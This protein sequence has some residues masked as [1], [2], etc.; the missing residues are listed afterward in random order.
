MAT[1]GAMALIAA[2]GIDL[3]FAN[4]SEAL[5]LAGAPDLESAIERLA[6]Q[7]K[8]L[9]F[10]R[11]PAGAVAYE[12][13]TLTEVPAISVPQVVDTTGAGDAFLAGYLAAYARGLTDGQAGL[14]AG[15]RW[16]AAMVEL[17]ASIPPPWPSVAG[18]PQTLVSGALG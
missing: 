8:T 9:V 3:I 2:G 10:T 15:A 17:E 16:A 12:G 4:E 13:G 11:G 14:E 5:Q 6:A 18:L 7:V 1:G